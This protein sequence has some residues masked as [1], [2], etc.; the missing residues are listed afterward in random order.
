MAHQLSSIPSYDFGY[1]QGI[2][3]YKNLFAR[4]YMQVP[5]PSIEIFDWEKSRSSSHCRAIIFPGLRLTIVRFSIAATLL[6]SDTKIFRRRF[7]SF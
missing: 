4:N 5:V 7:A 3:I 1:T 6:I 2:A